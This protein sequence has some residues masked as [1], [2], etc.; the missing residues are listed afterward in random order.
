[1]PEGSGTGPGEVDMTQSKPQTDFDA[2]I[3]KALG[4]LRKLVRGAVRAEKLVDQLTLLGN[5]EALNG[6]IEARIVDAAKFWL[7]F[8]EVDRFKSVND[9]YG[10]DSADELLRKIAQQLRNAAEN[11]FAKGVIPF[12]AHGDEFFM[13]GM[14][15]GAGVG[16]ALDYLRMAIGAI[17][18][19]AL[20]RPSPMRCT[21][22]IGWTTSS[23][24]HAF[25]KDLTGR[26]LRGILETAVAEAKRER[27]RVLRYEPGME[28]ATGRE[29]RADCGVCRA[30][31][32]LWVMGEVQ[33][34]RTALHCPNCWAEVER[35]I[36]L[37]PTLSP[38]VREA[39][40]EDSDALQEA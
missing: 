36:S 3:E 28:K 19:E 14:G 27:N 4:E 23:D 31:F 6:W 11:F 26:G 8:I 22:S 17:R 35:P 9:E 37:R 16:E 2:D 5:D 24:V 39:P 34:V 40:P 18:V 25:G 33:T 7:A 20:P 38:D 32:T 1:M 10:Y 13:G 30:K 29:G 15:D 12:R 21:V